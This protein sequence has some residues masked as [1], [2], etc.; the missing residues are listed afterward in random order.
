MANLIS[1]NFM[2]VDVVGNWRQGEQYGRDRNIQRQQDYDRSQLRNLAPAVV[3]GDIAAY[4]QA[5]AI[6]P[7]AASQYQAAGDNQVRRTQGAIQ[8]MDQAIAKGPQAA[9]AAYQQVRPFLSRFGQEAPATWAEAE[10][11]FQQAK[12][13]LAAA[14][15]GSAAGGDTVQ[16]VQRDDQGNLLAVMRGGGTRILGRADPGAV[17]QTLTVDVNG[18]PTQFTFDKRTQQYT[19]ATA[20]MAQAASPMQSVNG[21]QTY[22]DPS[23]PPD[24]QAAIRAGAADSLQDGGQLTIQN[25]QRSQ[26]IAG[27]M[28]PLTGRR[29]EDEAAAVEQARLS[30]QQAYLPAELGM[31]TQAAIQQAAG[32]ERAK[33]EVG[34]E[35]DAI[36]DYPRYAQEAGQTISLIDTALN[37]PGLNTA[38][39]LSGRIDPRNLIPGTDAANFRAILGQIKGKNFLQAFQSLKGGG[40]ITEVEG[41]KAEQAI[42]RLDT[43]QSPEAFREALTELKGIVEKGRERASQKYRHAIGSGQQSPAA[44]VRRA[45]NPRTGETLILVNGQ[46]VRE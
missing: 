19:P 46:W 30:A 14:Q 24:V 38:T 32:S 31:R 20:G 42:A 28:A 13:A 16:S 8:F 35:Q 26:V 10:P 3:G 27:T 5:A 7:E 41:Q 43:T 36:A 22:I 25:P 1:P 17:G 37:H 12:L 23:L 21:Q 45:R 40:A 6:N 9:E 15:A 34:R 44:A 4:D 11:K 2:P 39:G 18:T 33:A 29:K